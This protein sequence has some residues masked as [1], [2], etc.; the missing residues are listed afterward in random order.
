[1]KAPKL[2]LQ[3][4]FAPGS[5]RA[6][7]SGRIL[8][9]AGLASLGF[10]IA[11]WSDLWLSQSRMAAE[12]TGLQERSAGSTRPVVAKADP[13]QVASTKA[14]RQVTS[15]LMTPWASLLTSLG[16]APTGAVALLSVEPSVNKHS[17]RLTA[18]ARDL[19]GMLDYLGA[20]QRDE[21]LS[22]VVLVA[23]QV[24]AQAPGTPVRFQIQ[25]AWGDAR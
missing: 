23:H 13:K 12:L 4:E 22:A 2:Q 10:G 7:W 24:Q 17:V 8:L 5:R 25:A 6:P 1:M 20:L 3:L 18:E 9:L 16:A 14:L 15:T 19:Q 11:Q 21:R